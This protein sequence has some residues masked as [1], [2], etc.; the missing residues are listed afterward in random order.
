ME[1][2]EDGYVNADVYK[3]PLKKKNVQSIQNTR[4]KQTLQCT[5]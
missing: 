4:G 3:V 2:G 1:S 5:R